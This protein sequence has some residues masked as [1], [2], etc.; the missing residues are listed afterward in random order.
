MNRVDVDLPLMNNM[1][2]IFEQQKKLDVDTEIDYIFE[3]SARVQDYILVCDREYLS[4][5]QP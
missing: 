5:K 1:Q 4:T 3:V 2:V